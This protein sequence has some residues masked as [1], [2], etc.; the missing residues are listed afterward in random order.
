MIQ[1][2]VPD[3]SSQPVRTLGEVPGSPQVPE[4][5]KSILR[6]ATLKASAEVATKLDLI[7]Q[8]INSITLEL[9]SHL[10]N[11]QTNQS[12]IKQVLNEL[13]DLGLV[14]EAIREV[15]QDVSQT[16]DQAVDDYEIQLLTAFN[17]CLGSLKSIKLARQLPDE[18]PYELLNGETITKLLRNFRMRGLCS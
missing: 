16:P 6:T 14:I 11:K 10:P 17:L 5:D 8:L 12:I 18:T 2:R 15:Y 1:N 7:S 13:H 3:V 9:Q 4:Q